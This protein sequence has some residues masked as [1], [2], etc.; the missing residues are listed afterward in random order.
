MNSYSAIRRARPL[1]WSLWLWLWVALLSIL[2]PA[3]SA[4]GDNAAP[5]PTISVQTIDTA[6]AVVGRAATLSVRASRADIVYRRPSVTG[7]NTRWRDIASRYDMTEASD[8]N[9]TS[10]APLPGAS[11]IHSKDTP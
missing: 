8:D 1:C 11:L 4:C 7:G 10:V 2:M 9:Q 5:A 3:L 6:A